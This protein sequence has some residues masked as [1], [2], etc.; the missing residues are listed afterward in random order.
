MNSRWNYGFVTGWPYMPSFSGEKNQNDPIR[1]E[2]EAIWSKSWRMDHDR[3]SV[4]TLAPLTRPL[5][6]GAN[7]F[8]LLHWRNR[9]VETRPCKRNNKTHLLLSPCL[10]HLMVKVNEIRSRT[11]NNWSRSQQ[12]SM[13]KCISRKYRQQRLGLHKQQRNNN[14]LWLKFTKK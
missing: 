7:Q 4:I 5:V 3:K 8:I 2:W 10:G 13:V 1:T 14:T 6:S 9:T 11:L 12:R